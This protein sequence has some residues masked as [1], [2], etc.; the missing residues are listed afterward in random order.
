MLLS[1]QGEFLSALEFCTGSSQEL[2]ELRN[3]IEHNTRG[4][5]VAVQPVQPVAQPVVQPV[6]GIRAVPTAVPNQNAFSR[7]NMR[8]AKT[9]PAQT[10]FTPAS[11]FTPAATSGYPSSMPQPMSTGF[12]S[13][14]PQPAM[15]LAPAVN[16]IKP[17]APV[18]PVVPIAPTVPTI[19][20]PTPIV[21]PVISQPINPPMS[22][23]NPPMSMNQ[24]HYNTGNMYGGGFAQADISHIP[25]GPA[26]DK[27]EGTPG[28]ND[29]GRKEYTKSAVDSSMRLNKKKKAATSFTPAD[30]PMF[31]PA[32]TPAGSL[33]GM[34]GPMG[35]QMGRPMGG[36]MGAPM[37]G[38]G[39]P[40][41]M[42]GPSNMA[43]MAPS[44]AMGQPPANMMAPNMMAPMGNSMGAPMGG[45][46]MMKPMSTPMLQPNINQPSAFAPTGHIP[47]QPAGEPVEPIGPNSGAAQVQKPPLPEQYEPMKVSFDN[48]LDRCR[49]AP[50]VNAVLKKKLDDAQKRLNSLYDK[51]RKNSCSQIGKIYLKYSS[52]ITR[53]FS[54][55]WH[56]VHIF[57]RREKSFDATD[58]FEIS[59]I[60]YVVS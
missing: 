29:P 18:N 24:P 56:T 30:V 13:S 26:P 46:S 33:G 38:M 7:S 16:E 31:T 35:G 47:G 34:P 23:F 36:H 53:S 6:T 27:K 14:M 19:A 17:L 22:T 32:P 9:Q 49:N 11:S 10:S 1:S 41:P 39:G 37:G 42:G 3:R 54:A 25:K 45:S 50:K 44:N 20:Q 40:P 21:A 8:R 12:P 48:L 4:Q 55:D 57:L 51:L 2:L 60:L 58:R 52:F 28:W 15:P 43:H 5:S 59:N